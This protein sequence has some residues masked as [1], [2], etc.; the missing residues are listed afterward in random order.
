[1]TTATTPE[2]AVK[3]VHDSLMA[4]LEQ[5]AQANKQAETPSETNGQSEPK[6]TDG[7]SE[8]KE[9]PKTTEKSED[10][11]KEVKVEIQKE[12]TP[13]AETAKA[14]KFW[15]K[16]GKSK[17]KETTATKTE[18]IDYESKYKELEA[19][20]SSLKSEREKAELTAEAKLAK[21]I[22]ESGGIDKLLGRLQT[23]N[24]SNKTF[25]QLLKDRTVRS[26]IKLYGKDHVT[27]DLIEDQLEKV[28]D[29][30]VV[31]Q[32]E[33]AEAERNFQLQEFNKQLD[34]FKP[35]QSLKAERFAQDL[36]QAHNN[37]KGKEFLG[38]PMT[39][40]RYE[41][42]Q[43]LL[44]NYYEGKQE[45]TGSDL[46]EY[47]FFK[48][49]QEEIFEN[50]WSMDRTEKLEAEIEKLQGKENKVGNTRM[51]DMS[52]VLSKNEEEYRSLVELVSQTGKAMEQKVAEKIKH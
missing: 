11:N 13:K 22:A 51:N 17:E 8:S 15:E 48:A 47:L 10:N 6:A 29:K 38:L 21:K 12:K 5:A 37:A 32:E 36:E 45:L 40:Y 19:Q 20:F 50:V 14:K 3:T 24:P 41:Q 16:S 1:M 27:D 7:N 30:D 52:T 9:T 2:A 43:Q 46:Y 26:L 33:M 42:M 39:D 35:E 25:D 23:E 18:V 49:N 31:T 28:K 44:N 4:T 34:E